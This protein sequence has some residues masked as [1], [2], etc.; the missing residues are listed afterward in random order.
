MVR[1]TSHTQV[2]ASRNWEAKNRR[3]A[4]IDAYR[5]QA[6]NFIRNH[7]GLEDLMELKELIRKKEE[8]LMHHNG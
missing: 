4:T 1:K 7:A 6:R 8:T 2:R 5:R 3:K